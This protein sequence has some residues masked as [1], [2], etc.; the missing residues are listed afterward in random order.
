SP[1]IQDFEGNVTF[2]PSAH[3]MGNGF[4]RFASGVMTILCVMIRRQQFI[5]YCNFPKSLLG[6]ETCDSFAFKCKKKCDRSSSD[7]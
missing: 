5:W 2:K 3:L 7:C 4:Q 6:I 1:S